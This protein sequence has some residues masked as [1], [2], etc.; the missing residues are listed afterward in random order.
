MK[1]EATVIVGVIMA[2]LSLLNIVLTPED[3]QAVQVIVEAVILAGGVTAIRGWVASYNT[4][5][6]ITS[7]TTAK[8]VFR[9]S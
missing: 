3:M 2:I 1:S 4:V 8:V 7:D 6:K 5:E 9:K